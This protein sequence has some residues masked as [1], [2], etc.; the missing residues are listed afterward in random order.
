MRLEL[1]FFCPSPKTKERA[2]ELWQITF[3]ERNVMRQQ[4]KI[5]VY[6]NEYPV[7]SAFNG[8]MIEL[9]FT[10]LMP[11]AKKFAEE[12]ESIKPKILQIYHDAYLNISNDVLRTFALI[13]KQNPTRGVK[14]TKDAIQGRE[15][16][17]K[18]I[19][20]PLQPDDPFPANTNLDVPVLYTKPNCGTILWKN[21]RVDIDGDILK[22]IELFFKFYY[23]INVT[24][25]LADK[26]FFLFIM[27]RLFGVGNFSTTGE[28][29]IRSLQ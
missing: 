12:F 1:K 2:V 16:P 22:N 10:M 13:R 24:S 19:I 14:R 26:Q 18:G 4:S 7:F 8:L 15:N 23:F 28:K 25:Q 5:D 20:E 21:C 11:S 17:L 9:D 29:F 3:D 6:M 27:A